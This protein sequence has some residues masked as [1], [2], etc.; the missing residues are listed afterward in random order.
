[1]IYYK[2]QR[3]RSITLYEFVHD[4]IVHMNCDL[5]YIVVWEEFIGG[6]PAE[7]IVKGSNKFYAIIFDFLFINF[8]YIYLRHLPGLMKRT[9]FYS[10]T[11]H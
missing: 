11:N 1:M 6:L 3:S 9:Y 10:R 7:W 5:I 2:K 8:K 4:Y